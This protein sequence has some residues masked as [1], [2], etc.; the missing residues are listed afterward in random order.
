MLHSSRASRESTV[1]GNRSKPGS[2]PALRPGA[3]RNDSAQSSARCCQ[4]SK[5]V[6][7]FSAS[8]SQ[9]VAMSPSHAKFSI[10]ASQSQTQLALQLMKVVKFSS[11]VRQLFLQTAAHR[12]AWLQ[13]PLS[14]FQ[15]PADLARRESETLHTADESQRLDVA[16][17]VLTEAA[18]RP[19]RTG[20]QSAALVE[21]DRVGR[22]ANSLRNRA[23][24][25]LC[26]LH[27]GPY[28]RVK[29]DLA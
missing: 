27:S 3:R 15:K 29:R 23:N 10:A 18:S 26:N 25:S 14:K 1:R 28:S 21:P 20:E 17:P 7:P 2:R 16:F 19:G 8:A 12:G 13:P 11:Y 6:L 24:V 9:D 5:Y 22:H 4:L